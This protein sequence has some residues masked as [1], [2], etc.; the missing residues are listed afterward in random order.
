MGQKCL[1]VLKDLKER[2]ALKTASLSLKKNIKI[3]GIKTAKKRDPHKPPPGGKERKDKSIEKLGA[4]DGQR[5]GDSVLGLVLQIR[6]FA[7]RSYRFQL[8]VVG[9]F[10]CGSRLF[11]TFERSAEKP[12]VERVLALWTNNGRI[13]D[14]HAC[15]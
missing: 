9:L 14:N 2:E 15:S 7:E 8:L 5:S 12:V 1:K 10:F 13:L 4:E 6:E 3:T 11:A